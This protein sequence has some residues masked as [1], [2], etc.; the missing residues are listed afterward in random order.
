MMWLHWVL[1]GLFALLGMGCLLL[2][3][4]QL[5]GVWILLVLGLAV[6][7]IDV[8]WIHGDDA[9][10][11]WWALGLAAILA[12]IGEVLENLAGAAGA[13][14][15]GGSRRSMWGGLIGGILG[16]IFGTPIIPI[17]ILGTFIGAVIGAFAGAFLGEVTGPNPMRTTEA[18]KPAAGAA[19][20]RAAGTLI[21]AG[22]AVAIWVIVLAGLLIR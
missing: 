1:T 21:K 18:M 15:G 22:I 8:T 10:A 16:A 3:I 19:T 7:L 5:P 12:V 13:R 2:V 9:T 6:Q 20:G 4:M 17:P 14:A 11:G